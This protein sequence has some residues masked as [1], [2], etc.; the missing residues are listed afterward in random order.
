MR[1]GVPP[2]CGIYAFE[3][4]KIQ[5]NLAKSSREAAEQ[6]HCYPNWSVNKQRCIDFIELEQG[7]QPELKSG[8]FIMY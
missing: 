2:Q 6:Q 7:K 1:S 5:L 4:G 3:L 8:C